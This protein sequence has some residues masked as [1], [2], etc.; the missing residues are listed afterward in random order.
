MLLAVW[1]MIVFSSLNC[2]HFF[3][4]SIYF[5][6]YFK[7]HD[8]CLL[9]CEKRGSDDKKSSVKSSSREKQSE[10][11]NTESRKAIL[12]MRSMGPVKTLNLKV[13]LQSN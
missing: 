3:K 1:E 8:Q 5:V 6:F 7:I 12:R 13:T 10:D 11:T 2:F 9:L 4:V